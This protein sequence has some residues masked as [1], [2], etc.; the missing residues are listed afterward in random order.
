LSARKL[1]ASDWD[2]VCLEGLLAQGFDFANGF[3]EQHPGGV[4]D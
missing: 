4:W 1:S 2:D 3:F